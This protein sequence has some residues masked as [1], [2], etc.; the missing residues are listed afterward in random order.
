MKSQNVQRHAFTT[1]FEENVPVLKKQCPYSTLLSASENVARGAD[2]DQRSNLGI[3]SGLG[4]RCN[5]HP[6]SH[7]CY[8]RLA[9]ILKI[10]E[11]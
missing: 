9:A 3:D 7:E 2:L 6:E 4:C 1:S 8:A 10:K 5:R 11:Q